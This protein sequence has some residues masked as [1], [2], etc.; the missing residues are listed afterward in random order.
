VFDRNIPPIMTVG[1]AAKLLRL[2]ESTLREWIFQRRM[3]VIRLGRAVRLKKS[4]I[5]ALI[6]RSTDRALV[7]LSGD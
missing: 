2:S 3:P 7:Q 5:E 1:E 6:E 4:D